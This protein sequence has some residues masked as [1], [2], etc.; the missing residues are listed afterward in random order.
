[1]QIHP[2]IWTWVTATDT[3]TQWI[4]TR[5]LR[6]TAGRTTT[7]QLMTALNTITTL[8]VAT[9]TLTWTLEGIS[10][11]DRPVVTPSL[12]FSLL[13][14]FFL[15]L[16]TSAYIYF[17]WLDLPCCMRIIWLIIDSLVKSIANDHFYLFVWLTLCFYVCAVVV[18]YMRY[19][20]SHRAS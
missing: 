14:S 13:F 17:E 18:L 20:H 16:Q 5:I 15:F 12:S 7:T 2:V 11:S 3:R 8:I 1:M 9:T 19:I 4:R 6:C 10:V